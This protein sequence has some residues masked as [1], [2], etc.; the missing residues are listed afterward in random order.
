VGLQIHH[1]DENPANTVDG[2]LVAICATCH[3][4]YKHGQ[5]S[6]NEAFRVKYYLIEGKPPFPLLAAEPAP[7]R[8]GENTS[9]NVEVN[10][11]QVAGKIVNNH[12]GERKDARII[13]P[14]TIAEDPD[15]YNYL[16]YIMERLAEF[17]E[18]G[19]GFGQKRKGRIHVGI[20]RNMVKN[21]WG[22]LPKN[23]RTEKW[24]PLVGQLKEKIDD[25]ALGR[26]R[27]SRGQRNYHSFEDHLAKGSKE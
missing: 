22:A 21:E 4:R 2:N 1:L 27:R 7:T 16:E 26:V 18:A 19:S 13:L 8:Q 14:G 12:Y 17:R 25:T 3:E 24:E 11:G 6:R 10:Q 9:I 23:L 20:I 15:R 5:I